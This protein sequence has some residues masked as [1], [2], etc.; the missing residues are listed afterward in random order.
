MATTWGINQDRGAGP[1]WPAIGSHLH[2]KEVI[3]HVVGAGG[4]GRDD[5]WASGSCDWLSRRWAEPH[6]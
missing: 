6:F 2:W 4:G 3:G 1:H 5:A